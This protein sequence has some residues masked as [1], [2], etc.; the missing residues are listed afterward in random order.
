MR[1]MASIYGL[2]D[3]SGALRYIGKANDPEARLKG[4]VYDMS[5]KKSALYNW[6]RKNGVPQM[7][8]IEHDCADWEESE[9]RLIAEARERGDK[10]LNIADGGDQ[11][12]CSPEVRA[13]NG[14]KNAKAIHS[15]PERK[16]FWL[17]KRNLAQAIRDGFLSN[18]KRKVLREAAIRYPESLSAFAN[19]PDR[20]E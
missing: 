7:R 8:V 18:E 11:P 15:S 9:R 12:Y 20:V 1:G 3:Q 19:I 13:E 16:R 5:K 4:H 14:R 2:Y 10:L 17:I 6:M